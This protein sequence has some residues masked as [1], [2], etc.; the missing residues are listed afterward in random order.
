MDA[1]VGRFVGTFVGVLEGLK[2]GISMLVGPVVGALVG[3]LEPPGLPQESL[4]PFGAEMA[5]E[6]ALDTE[7]DRAK[8]PPYSSRPPLVV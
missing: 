2:T 7:Y 3:D 8:I 4:G 5:P 6:C 1:F